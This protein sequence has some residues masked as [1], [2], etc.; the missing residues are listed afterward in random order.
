MNQRYLNSHQLALR[1]AKTRGWVIR[2]K[3]KNGEVISLQG[4]NKLGQPVY[5][6]TNDN[7][8]AAATTQTNKVQPGGAAGLSLSGSGSVLNNKLAIFDGGSVLAS[9]QEF[10]GKTITLHDNTS[11]IDHATH[12]AGTMIAKGVY[13]PAKGMAFGAATLESYDFDNDVSKMS[14]AAPGLLLSN[15]S[16][17]DVAG[18]N[19]NDLTNHWEWYGLPGDTVDYHFGFYGE[20]TQQ[21]DSVAFMAPQYLIVESAGNSRG[22]KRAACWHRLLWLRH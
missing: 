17:G 1:L 19:F 22:G 5:L 7:I 6:K 13:P 9:H 2:R 3:T 20:R 4:L 14:A 10:A 12:V 8:I 16:Y 15:H 21:F 11:V 18:W